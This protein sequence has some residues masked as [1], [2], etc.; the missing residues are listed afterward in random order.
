MKY[1]AFFSSL[2]LLV[3]GSVQAAEAQRNGVG[4][5]P[6]VSQGHGQSGVNDHAKTNSSSH[7]A[8]SHDT[9]A[10]QTKFNDRYQNDAAFRTRIQKLLPPGADVSPAALQAMESGFKNHGQFTA[11]LHVSHNLNIPFDQ[12][13]AKMTGV[14]TTATG[15]TVTS[16]KES[17]GKAIHELRPDL[18]QGAANDEAKKAEQQA[19]TTEKTGSTT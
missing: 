16:P 5:A 11:A 8:S 6:S 7:D 18:S 1:L 3:C 15:E 13:K 12:L 19:S 4:H 17:L 14:T 10:W 9:N 2:L